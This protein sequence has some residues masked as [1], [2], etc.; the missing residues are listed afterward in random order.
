MLN[1]VISEKAQNE[2]TCVGVVLAS[3]QHAKP[4]T[5]IPLLRARR[6]RPRG[7][8]AAEERDELAPSHNVQPQASERLDYST[9]RA[10]EW[11]LGHVIG[12]G[13][14]SGSGH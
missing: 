7:R 1:R 11:P 8:R 13:P 2:H 9:L 12:D 14:M 5:A 3:D 6:Q 4:S 10:R